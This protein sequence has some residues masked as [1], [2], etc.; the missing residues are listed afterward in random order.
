MNMRY[1]LILW[2]LP[3]GL[4]ALL[5]TAALAADDGKDVDWQKAKALYQRG[6]AGQTLSPEEQAYLD[7]AKKLRA[8]PNSGRVP[9]VSGQKPAPAGTQTT[10][11]PE[12]PN[13][14]V[15]GVHYGPH[16]LQVI[17]LWKAESRERTPL[18]VFIH[19]GGFRAGDTT[20]IHPSLI[21]GCLQAGISVASIGYRLSPE[22]HFPDHFMDCARAIQFLR[23]HSADYNIDPKRIAG[24]G[25]SAGAGTALWLGMHDDFA[26]PKN[27]DPILRESTRLN[28]VAVL[29]AQTSY[30][31]RSIREWIGART[32]EHPDA[33]GFFGLPPGELDTPRAHQVFEQASPINL[34]T[35]DDPPVF[36]IYAGTKTKVIAADAKPG[37]GIHHAI[38]GVKLK[39]KMDALGM[40]CVLKTQEDYPDADTMAQTVAGYRD[41]VGFLR[42]HLGAK[43]TK[44]ER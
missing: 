31:L 40:E 2:N 36:L 19:G 17:D 32:A 30:D 10:K 29:Q 8:A 12:K 4:L 3:S 34:L 37:E 28:C 1:R 21:V 11:S 44:N 24:S 13:A 14:T 35:R 43:S 39:E 15:R 33:I 7:R 23:A 16:E 18:V 41:L 22:V 42:D 6:Q 25:S 20:K 26:D 27:A 5:I 38:F 9:A